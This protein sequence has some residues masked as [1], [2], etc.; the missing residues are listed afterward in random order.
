MNTTELY[1]RAER[2]RDSLYLGLK[3]G[4]SE[5]KQA[6]LDAA[7]TEVIKYRNRLIDEGNWKG[8]IP[9]PVKR[10]YR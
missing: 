7:T 6:A 5:Q 2:R 10:K 8:P 1:E 3:N 4:M 9:I